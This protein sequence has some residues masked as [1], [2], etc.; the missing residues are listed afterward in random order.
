MMRVRRALSGNGTLSLLPLGIYVG[1]EK[2][3]HAEVTLVQMN[4][5][6]REQKKW[7]RTEAYVPKNIDGREKMQKENSEITAKQ[8]G[9]R[10]KKT[11]GVR[12]IKE[13][14]ESGSG[15]FMK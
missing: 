11:K 13:R 12:E 3:V 15:T 10:R 2:A 14:T 5:R 8:I 1:L 4:G 9:Q 7:G 6:E